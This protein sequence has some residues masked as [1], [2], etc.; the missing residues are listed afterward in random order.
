MHPPQNEPTLKCPRGFIRPANFSVSEN[1]SWAY[2]MVEA[3]LHVVQVIGVGRKKSSSCQPGST[4]FTTDLF[5]A[6]PVLWSDISLFFPGSPIQLVKL[7][8]DFHPLL[9]GLTNSY[10]TRV[11][12]RY[13]FE[14][15]R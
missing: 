13:P 5:F 9:L 14:N 6:A 10:T 4:N 12:V 2:W 15:V 8:N 1:V 11:Y 7:L 3:L